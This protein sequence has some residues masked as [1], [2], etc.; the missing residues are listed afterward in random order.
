M[1]LLDTDVMIDVMRGYTPAVS[2]LQALNLEPIAIPGLVA[3]ELL[4]GCHDRT[5]QQRVETILRS[6]ALYWPTQAD[7]DR[8][9]AD[10]A[11]YRLSHGMG[12]LDALIAATAVGLDARL[13]TFNE[14]H[15]RM[16][17]MLETVQP[18]ERT[19]P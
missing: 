15:Y 3:M 14:K 5:E 10:F 2:W 16:V 13:V 18:Y 8:A 11:A 1:L 9:F 7:C 4:Q 12:I 17:Y 19:A 6:Y